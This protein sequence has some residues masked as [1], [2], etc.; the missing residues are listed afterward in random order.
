MFNS[1]CSPVLDN[2]LYL[3]S[4]VVARNYE[5]L[6]ENGIT[7]VINTAADYSA[8][9]HKNKG[10]KYLEFHLKDGVRENIECVF[11]ETIQFMEKAK[12]EGGRVYIHCV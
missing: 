3:G 5:K 6:R 10:I 9:Y 1:V 12:Q 11:Y 2:F 4:D 7:H 8:S